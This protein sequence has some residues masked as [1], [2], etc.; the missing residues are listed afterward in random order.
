M[1]YKLSAWTSNTNAIPVGNPNGYNILELAEVDAMKISWNYPLGVNVETWQN[2][3]VIFARLIIDGE[4][5]S[6][7]DQQIS[8]MELL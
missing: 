3:D 8:D 5:V 7:D 1:F 2:E 4:Q 6:S